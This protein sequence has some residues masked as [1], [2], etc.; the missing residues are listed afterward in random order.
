[1]KIPLLAPYPIQIRYTGTDTLHTIEFDGDGGTADAG[2]LT[3]T[4]DG[5]AHALDLGDAAND[6]LAELIAVINALEDGNGETSWEAREYRS[7]ELLPISGTV[8]MDT[9]ERFDDLDEEGVPPFWRSYL[10]FASET[11]DV[12]ATTT[13]TIDRALPILV[14]GERFMR[15][16]LSVVLA[17]AGTSDVTGLLVS[18]AFPEYISEPDELVDADYTTDAYT[19]DLP[20]P[21]NGDTAVRMSFQLDLAGFEAVKLASINNEN[22]EIATIKGWLTDTSVN[23]ER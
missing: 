23:K 15:I 2:L 22:S 7:F 10:E 16:E 19:G 1:V 18:A 21:A 5:G 6:T 3:L 20:V 14:S 13:G 4:D 17:D 12:A 11:E 8:A 9:A